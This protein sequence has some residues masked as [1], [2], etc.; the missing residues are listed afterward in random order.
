[1]DQACMI[2]D[3]KALCMQGEL[4]ALTE[5]GDV[6]MATPMQP[7]M[8]PNGNGGVYEALHK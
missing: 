2:H 4:P 8:S 3:Q 5:E 1:M 7:A 6:I